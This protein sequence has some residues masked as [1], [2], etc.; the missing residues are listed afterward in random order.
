MGGGLAALQGPHSWSLQL[1]HITSQ[2]TLVSEE[3]GVEDSKGAPSTVNKSL[4]A[5]FLCFSIPL[6]K[7]CGMWK[8]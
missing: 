3:A 5:I 1:N 4:P 2:C 7:A 6:M 8:H